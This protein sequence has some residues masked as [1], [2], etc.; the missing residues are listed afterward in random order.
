[1]II[2]KYINHRLNSVYVN[3]KNDFYLVISKELIEQNKIQFLY[4]MS[5]KLK[6]LITH[7]KTHIQ[8]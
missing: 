7:K 2:F 3:G 5:C 8:K 4:M 1:M 6:I